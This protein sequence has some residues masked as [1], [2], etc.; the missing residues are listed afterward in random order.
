M[1][2]RLPLLA[3]PPTTATATANGADAMSTAGDK[4]KQDVHLTSLLS[5]LTRSLAEAQSMGTKFQVVTREKA[6]RERGPFG[7]P[8]GGPGRPGG[9]GFGHEGGLLSGVGDFGGS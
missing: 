4:E 8:G 7:G 1:L 5:T 2:A 6:A 3:P 9:M